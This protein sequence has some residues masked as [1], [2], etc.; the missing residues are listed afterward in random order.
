MYRRAFLA[1]AGAAL[2]AG[3][4]FYQGGAS[5]T[6]ETVTPITVR[7]PTR[8]ETA[9]A[10]PTPDASS[11]G[12]YD[13]ERVRAE[14]VAPSYAELVFDYGSFSGDPVTFAYGYVYRTAELTRYDRY[15]IRVSNNDRGFEGSIAALWFGDGDLSV[16]T[17][18]ELWGI[19]G[20]V[21]TDERSGSDR[22]IPALRLVSYDRLDSSAIPFVDE[23]T[24]AD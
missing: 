6:P 9:T 2:S 12:L 16:G 17:Y 10:A 8:S 20:R 21:Y 24:G 1:L 7:E 3:C 22:T 15:L 19:P 18:V 14:A 11:A 23:D 5:E 13:P 4:A